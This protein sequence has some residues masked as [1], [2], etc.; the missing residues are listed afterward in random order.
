MPDADPKPCLRDLIRE[1]A[2]TE[3]DDAHSITRKNEAAVPGGPLSG[4]VLAA[5]MG[6][7]VFLDPEGTVRCF[8]HSGKS[9]PLPVFAV[10]SALAIIRQRYP[11]LHDG[12]AAENSAPGENSA[13]RTY[14]YV[15][16]RRL[17]EQAASTIDRLEPKSGPELLGWLRARS[18]L[19]HA[20]LTYVVM[21]TG[22]LRVSE[23]HAEHVAC[24]QA[25]DVLAAGELEVVEDED[26]IW[27]EGVTKQST[28]YCPEPRCFAAVR[29][30]LEG[31]GLNVPDAFSHE[32]IFRRCPECATINIVKED[33]FECSSCGNGLPRD[34][35]FERLAG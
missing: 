1:V 10:S 13:A 23:R 14:A 7:I 24:A 27:V 18:L 21:P 32:F 34:W 35:N 12:V 3:W 17:L 20:T 15:G 22:R 25:S 26:S 19:P 9:L 33:D 11:H 6:G 5:D 28:G 2:H 31:I 29:G 8:D 4:L 16:P 30:S